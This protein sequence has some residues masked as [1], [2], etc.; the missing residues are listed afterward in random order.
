M[1]IVTRGKKR[2]T[3]YVRLPIEDIPPEAALESDDEIL[4]AFMTYQCGQQAHRVDKKH[5]KNNAKLMEM[6]DEFTVFICGFMA[7]LNGASRGTDDGPMLEACL[8]EFDTKV[9]TF[10]DVDFQI[11]SERIDDRVNNFLGAAM[12][13]A[14]ADY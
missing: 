9:A 6:A 10:T 3:R 12:D 1:C 2:I 13:M 7:K 11:L 4:K 14:F 5:V 8:R